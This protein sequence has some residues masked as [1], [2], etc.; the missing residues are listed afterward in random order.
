[1]S[2]CRCLQEVQAAVEEQC[3]T[4]KVEGAAAVKA[5]NVEKQKVKLMRQKYERL[6]TMYTDVTN[7]ELTNAE[8]EFKGPSD[9]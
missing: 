2:C 7:S 9:D 5:I 1:M 3:E 6:A 4:L 8:S